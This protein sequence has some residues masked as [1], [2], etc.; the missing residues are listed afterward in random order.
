MLNCRLTGNEVRNVSVL[1]KIGAFEEKTTSHK[2]AEAVIAKRGA[3]KLS[4]AA[5]I[6][7]DGISDTDLL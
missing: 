5:R 2:K 3:N 7:R 6:F 4:Q 1:V